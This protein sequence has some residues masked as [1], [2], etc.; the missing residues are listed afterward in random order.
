MTLSAK[1]REQLISSF[2]AELA[3]HV[4]MITD[5]LLALEQRKQAGRKRRST[6][7]NIFRAAH[8]LKGA[9]RAVGV[10]V[11]EQLAHALEDVLAGLQRDALELT[12]ELFTACY[13]AL[14]AI[15]A[16][17]AAYEAGETTPPVQAL[18]ALADVEPFRARLKTAPA[19]TAPPEEAA[20]AITE[21][22]E[23][24][25]PVPGPAVDETI[26]VSVSKLDTLMA[27]LSELL[28]TKIRAEQRLTQ[29]RQLQECLA[30][31]QKEWL[32][33]RSAY[34]NLT[35]QSAGGRGQPERDLS[36]LLDY[37]ADSQERLRQMNA[38]IGNV[39]REYANDT[40][41][42]ALVIDQLEEE[43][44]RARM[45]PLSTITGPFGR[46]VRDLAQAGGKEA[47]LQFAGGETELD[48][49]VLEQIKDPLIHLL[50]NAIDH[51][52]E[53]P[54]RR[55]AL[56]KPRG[57][58]VTLTAEQLGKDVIINV[59][60]DGGGL[61]LEAIRQ[62]VTRLDGSDAQALTEA[63]LIEAIFRSGVSTSKIITDISGRG[64]G[65]DVVRRNV[66]ALQGRVF[67][68]WTHDTG[69]SFTLTLP[70]ALTSSRGLLVRTA[71]QLFAIPL[72]NVERILNVNPQEIAPLEGRD[73]IRYNNH[74]LPLVW[75]DDVL[76]LP[77]AD[78]QRDR[79]RIPAVILKAAERTMAFIVDELAGEQEVVIKGLGRQLVRVGGIAGSTIMGSGEIV[80]ILN[81][82][83]LIKLGLRGERHPVRDT[84]AET[85]SPAEA[86]AR[87]RIL[88]VDDSI[89]TRTLEKNIL[90]ATG[91]TIQVA[92]DGQEA[93]NVIAAGEPPDLIISDVIM[94]RVDGFELTRRIKGDPRIAHVPVILVTSLDSAEDK[95]KGIEAG[96]DAYIAKS[97]FAQT[98]LLETIEQLI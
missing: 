81:V 60:D 96:A 66:E 57:G 43:I 9:A 86:R 85:P 26:R 18:Q 27:H 68:E 13:R 98:T 80:L 78:I 3:E 44:K 24:V 35:R 92:T 40:T 79:T 72:N 58:V 56:G 76:E 31:W 97:A 12:P 23:A 54:E 59:A 84:L 74:P 48:K 70:L 4:Q 82:A 62:A 41:H 39:A 61:N 94:P 8:S 32:A 20:P 14:D 28:I 75:L 25:T 89:T 21:Q 16:V 22:A 33:A 19:E 45:L 17:Q 67:V 77:R 93:L 49:Q 64:I 46:M 36:R 1:V 87:Q 38:L 11:I 52:I 50:R 5:G 63:E 65:L 88:I 69:A 51:G 71:G 53:P 6:L 90:E 34:S 91:Y 2:R 95:T 15:Q 37:T 7:E 10:T 29:I 55:E 42:M 47:T 83:D 73:T 30:Q